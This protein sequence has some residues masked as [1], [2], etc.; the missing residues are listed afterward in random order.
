MTLGDR[1]VVGYGIDGLDDGLD[2]R[3]AEM[4]EVGAKI[5]VE[6]ARCGSRGSRPLTSPTTLRS[7]TN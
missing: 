4:F 1:G 6:L 2:D 7:S 3:D 5:R